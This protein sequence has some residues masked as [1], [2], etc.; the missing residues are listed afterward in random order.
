MQGAPDRELGA[1]MTARGERTMVTH[2]VVSVLGLLVV[3]AGG[4]L[5]VTRLG[6]EGRSLL[7]VEIGELQG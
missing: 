6:V 4:L 5:V 3:E 1:E 2:L 7:A